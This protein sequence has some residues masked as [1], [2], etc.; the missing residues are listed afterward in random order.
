[1]ETCT[2]AENKIKI[3]K[4]YFLRAFSVAVGIIIYLSVCS[5]TLLMWH[6]RSVKYLL[7]CPDREEIIRI[8]RPREKKRRSTKVDAN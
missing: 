7:K 6:V 5:S 3:I 1:M 8:F 4:Y 2:K